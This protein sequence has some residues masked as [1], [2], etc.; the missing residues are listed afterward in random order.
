MLFGLFNVP[1]TF[2]QV[3][4]VIPYTVRWQ[5]TLVDLYDI[6]VFSRTPE[7][8]VKH[9]RRVLRLRKHAGVALKLQNCAFITNRTYSL[10]DMIWPDPL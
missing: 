9:R 1:A 2:Q 6:C 10:G 3:I 4:D 5:Y 7:E 8:R